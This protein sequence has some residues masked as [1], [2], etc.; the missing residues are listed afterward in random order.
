MIDKIIN[1]IIKKID[2]TIKIIDEINKLDFGY[3]DNY[4]RN[5]LFYDKYSNC[6]EHILKLN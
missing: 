4:D 1:K 6:F 5:Y 3:R 2:K